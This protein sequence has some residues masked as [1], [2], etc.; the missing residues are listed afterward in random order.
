M[1][2]IIS[3]LVVVARLTSSNLG[4]PFIAPNQDLSY[5]NSIKPIFK[6]NW[7]TAFLLA[8]HH[9]LLHCIISSVKVNHSCQHGRQPRHGHQ[10]GDSMPLPLA[11]K[12]LVTTGCILLLQFSLPSPARRSG[13]RCQPAAGEQDGGLPDLLQPLGHEEHRG[14]PPAA[15]EEERKIS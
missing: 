4:F 6:R 2:F 7:V 8:I 1:I 14:Q 12:L 10:A 13:E 3:C 15:V 5:Q 11:A 9:S